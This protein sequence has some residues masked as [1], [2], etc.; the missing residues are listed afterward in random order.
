MLSAN[1]PGS[2]MRVATTSG[3][4]T[5]QLGPNGK[6]YRAVNGG[7]FLDV[8][9]SPEED[10]TLCDYAAS[11]VPLPP[12]TI[13]IFGLPPF[14]TSLF[15]ASIEAEGTCLGSDTNFRLQSRGNY[16]GVVWNFGDGSPT[17]AIVAPQHRYAAAG[18]YNVVAAVT[19]DGETENINQAITISAPAVAN[20]PPNV[21]GCDTDN[22]GFTTFNFSATTAAILGTQNTADFSVRYFASSSDAVAG[23]NA[24]NAVAFTNTANPQTIYARVQNNGSA[25]CFAT[26]SFQVS[27]GSL[28]ITAAASTF[29]LCDT[30]QD[31]N[32]ANG[33]ATFNMADVT[34]QL[35]QST[36]GYTVTYYTTDTAAQAGAI[37]GVL[38]QSFYN[39][40]P[41]AQVVYARIVNNLVPACFSVVPVTL[42]VN[43]LPAN[44]QNATL[45]QCDI[46]AAPDG[47]TQFNLTEADLQFTQGNQDLAVRYYRTA[48]HAQNDTNVITGAYTN[49][50]NPQPISAK[51]IN[52]VTGCY[53]ILPLELVVTTNTVAPITLEHCDDDGTEDGLTEFVLTDIG[54][55]TPG[56]TVVYYASENDALLEQNAVSST[57]TTTVPDRESIFARIETNNSCT[58]LQE[59]I[60]NVYALPDIE[61]TDTDIVC[62][63]TRDYITL[64]AGTNGNTN[65]RYEWS[66]GAITRTI[67]VNEPGTYTVTV[68]DLTHPLGQCS[69]ERTITVLPGNIARIDDVT[70][71]DLR[72]NN[73][74]TVMVS[75]IGNV[76]TTYLYSLDR[77]NG[78]WQPEPYFDDV[79][80][81]IHTLYVYDANGCGIV[82][83]Q[84]AV[85]SIPKFFTPNGDLSNDHWRIAGLNGTAYFNSTVYI[86]DRYG[87]LITDVNHNGAGWDGTFKGQPLPATDY[88]YVLTL[89]DGR[90]VKGHFSLLR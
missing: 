51:V 70:V 27:V 3:S 69:K 88:W 5:L 28:A 49:T 78:P 42:T 52:T 11:S 45:T 24:L 47:F 34:A 54:L 44:V 85:L 18:T 9:N 8:I 61:V 26:T 25:A 79:A 32:D 67:R 13:S 29:N 23:I 63:N 19:R 60:L 89:P 53:R 48:A 30:A 71:Q 17:S 38:S 77:P 36:T 75:P 31:G 82:K 64:D 74:I 39:T 83:Q 2:G 62:L 84:V 46:G 58:A 55:E 50:A 14:I 15:S 12:G 22:D 66:T 16:D 20:T 43:S 73:T 7:R 87:K 59:I 80:A 90:I 57:Y 68:T 72:D 33:Q 21:T 10:G 1:I 65:F 86:Y 35:L 37:A 41:N 4:T 40:T 6:I 76:N 81:G 56:N